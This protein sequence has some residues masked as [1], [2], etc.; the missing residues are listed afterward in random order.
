MFAAGMIGIALTIILILGP[1]GKVN[2]NRTSIPLDLKSNTVP[3]VETG[4][5]AIEAIEPVAAEQTALS[6]TKPA[7]AQETP[8]PKMSWQS[9]T[10]KEGDTLSNLFAQAGY[11]NTI[12]YSV[13]GKG[14][15]NKE[16]TRIFPGEDI[17]FANDDQQKLNN[18]KLTRSPLEFVTF[19]RQD[20][21][22]FASETHRRTPE[23]SVAYTEGEIQSSLFLAGQKAGMSQNQIMA[24][25]NIFGWDVDFA[26]DI[27]QGDRFSLVYE[28]LHLDGVKYKNGKILAATF[29]NQGRKLK[30]VLY[31]DSKGDENYFTP[32]GK[33]MRKAF[34]RTPVDF[35]RISSHFNLKRKHPVLH[36]VRA[37]RGTDYAAPTGTPVKA[38]GD[39]KVL[40]AG[41]K[42]GYGKTIVLQHGQKISTLYA[43][44]HKYARG[45]RSGARVKQGQVI[46]YVGS[47][48]MSTGPHLHYEFRVNGIHR[49]PVKVK[50]PHAQ[51]IAGAELALFEQQTRDT[52]AQLETLQNSY[53][54]ALND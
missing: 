49:N 17:A 38:A 10:V 21:N 33:S 1:S 13:L 47:T 25:S 26:L 14:N 5:S 24:L 52:L 7:T 19:N 31:K 9:F 46:G 16:L 12:M 2:A 8:E 23:V 54:I 15:R 20:D 34:I 42:G 51:P 36:K 27:R 35:A 18:I 29:E 37:H 50:L 28:E 45:V 40:S 32:D 53:Q 30:A 11:N 4:Q 41:T 39:G 43:H 3:T 22:T 48:G 6:G 44:L